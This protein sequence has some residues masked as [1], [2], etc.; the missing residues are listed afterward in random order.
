MTTN[1]RLNARRLGT[2][3]RPLASPYS[4]S[5]IPGL[6]VTTTIYRQLLNVDP[7]VPALRRV[8]ALLSRQ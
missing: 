8:A 5:E 3:D 4:T 7:E 2:I 1:A 6:S